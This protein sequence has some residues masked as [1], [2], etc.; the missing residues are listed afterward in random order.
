MSTSSSWFFWAVLSAG[1]AAL[2]AIFAK[3]GIRGIDSDFATL[4]RSITH[5]L[6]PYGDDVQF[7]P[8]HGPMSTFGDER[9][10]NPFVGDAVLAR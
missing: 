5:E 2:T 7:V 10:S 3:V 4:V 6:W 9:R 1:F 8:G